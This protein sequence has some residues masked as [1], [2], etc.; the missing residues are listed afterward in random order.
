MSPRTPLILLCA[1]ASLT[2]GAQGKYATVIEDT[3]VFTM[4]SLSDGTLTVRRTVEVYSEQGLDAALFLVYTD[5][6]ETLASFSGELQTKGGEKKSIKKKDL[7]TVSVAEGI[8][9]DGFM[10]GYRPS[11]K[12][13]P[14]TVSYSY[15]VQYRKGFAV[16]PAFVPVDMEK[17]D[18]KSGSFSLVVPSGTVIRSYAST[19]AGDAVFTPGD[20]TDR[21]EWR[22]RDYKGF[23]AEQYMPSAV[24]L[25]PLVRSSPDTFIIEGHPGRQGSWNELGKWQYSLLNEGEE[26]PA[27]TLESIRSLTANAETD[28]EKIRIL[29]RFLR[30]KT[31]YVSIQ[32]GIGG[33]K[34]APVAVV[35]KT[36]FG[37][38]KALTNYMRR[39]LKAVGIES[40]F[41]I[42]NTER[43]DFF[44]GY[45]S[46]GQTNHVILSVPLAQKADTLYL[47]CTNPALPL[48]YRHDNLAGHELILIQ[49]DGGH[50]VRAAA[51]PD[52]LHRSD[53]HTTIRL[54]TDGS[55]SLQVRKRMLTDQIEPWVGFQDRDE[56]GKRALMTRALNFQPQNLHLLSLTDNF[57]GYDGPGW[58][59]EC[60]AE[61]AFDVRAYGQRN[62][63]RMKV[64]VNP[65]STRMAAQRNERTNP[66]VFK[67]GA[68]FQDEILIEIPES[69]KVE[70]LPPEV[71]LEE[72]WGSF[73]ST[74]ETEGGTI[75]IRQVLQLRP[76]RLESEAFDAFRDF[77]RA[78]N[79]AYSSAI[80]LIDS[81][82]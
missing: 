69:M 74:V 77:T 46:F 10:T 55:A 22:I 66:L 56:Q 23:V 16:F 51:Y 71:K 15:T 62:G 61:Y 79:R 1:L 8:A 34:P 38:C 45:T 36:G 53:I 4:Q 41:T 30:D 81:Q 57:E 11:P 50:L 64:A 68:V 12:S 39:L 78:M 40:D 6:N 54:R 5:K 20:K 27:A 63:V 49:E 42:L 31:R 47:E 58:V 65:F 21:Y 7:L 70:A 67:A 80:M 25:V 14:F 28:L 33:Y 43:K 37:D 18:L 72:A 82:A 52:S 9:S 32:F 35:D 13:F 48:G 3:E 29:Y 44:P 75:R 73:R 59:P 19:S 60:T 76:C 2:L 17:T 24:D 26:L